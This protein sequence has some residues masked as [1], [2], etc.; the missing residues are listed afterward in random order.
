MSTDFNQTVNLRE[1]MEREK[2]AILARENRAIHSAVPEPTVPTKAKGAS[3][4]PVRSPRLAE[5]RR[6]ENIDQVYESDEEAIRRDLHRISRP[7]ERK[8]NE[9]YVRWAISGAA[10]LLVV[11]GAWWFFSRNRTDI[12]AAGT[13]E[14][15]WYAVKLINN[16]IYYGEISDTAA[17]PVVIENVYYDYDQ[18][19]PTAKEEEK[20]DTSS[21]RLVKRGKETHGPAG[22]MNIVRAQ[23]VY[24]E[25]LANDSKV[26]KAILDYEK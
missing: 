14:P 8:I 21:L 19:N 1:K 26:L 10:V 23:I 22:T 4:Q 16:E 25:P 11:S 13:S 17:D 2:A 9:K 24:M 5:S 20:S 7:T 12:P 15:Q 6:A 3:A 18:L